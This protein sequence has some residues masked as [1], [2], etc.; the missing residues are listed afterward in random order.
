MSMRVNGSHGSMGTLRRLARALRAGHQRWS[1]RRNAQLHG[2]MVV[3]DR[4]LA[5]IG[6]CRADLHAAKSGVIRIEH[7]ARTHGDCR[8][9]APIQELR[10]PPVEALAGTDLS[11]AA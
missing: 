5:A 4:A 6:V 7:I 3:R 9:M 1:P 11:V 10:Q 2:F 8:W